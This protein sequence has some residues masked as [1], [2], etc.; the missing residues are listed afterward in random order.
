MVA[1][2][3]LFMEY[4]WWPN[5]AWRRSWLR[6]I[7]ISVDRCPHNVRDKKRNTVE[8]QEVILL[9]KKGITSNCFPHHTSFLCIVIFGNTKHKRHMILEFSDLFRSCVSFLLFF[10]FVIRLFLLV[11]LE[12]FKEINI[13]FP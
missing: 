5:H 11:N 3:H 6:W 13:S 1:E 4:L 2:P 10:E 12:L 7:L 9:T 8:D